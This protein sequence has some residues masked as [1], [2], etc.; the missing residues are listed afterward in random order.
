MENALFYTLST[1][2]QSLATAFAL[3]GAFVLFRL[4]QLSA[5][6]DV[7]A[8]VVIKPYLP[9]SNARHLLAIGQ[10]AELVCYLNTQLP[11]QE[12]RLQTHFYEATRN[13]L[14]RSIAQRVSLLRQLIRAM[15]ATGV[16]I[17]SAVVGLAF[18]PKLALSPCTAYIAFAI[19]VLALIACLML[20]GKIILKATSDA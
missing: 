20:Y 17:T 2:A 15:L 3:L 10:F 8:A 1:I 11:Q 19:A 13:A 6:C 14:V 5:S 7:A 9:N 18:T 12:A 4:Q 16:V